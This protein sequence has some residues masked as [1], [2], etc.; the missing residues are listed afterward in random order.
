MV[1]APLFF[2]KLPAKVPEH[3]KSDTEVQLVIPEKVKLAFLRLSAYAILR[4]IV[5]TTISVDILS[6]FQGIGLSLSIAALTAA[7][8]SS[9][10]PYFSGSGP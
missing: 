10:D 8:C 7:Y 3:H 6:M 5:G 9:C 2:Y 1:W 4:A